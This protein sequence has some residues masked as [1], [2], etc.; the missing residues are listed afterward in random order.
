MSWE[1]DAKILGHHCG[2]E[3]TAIKKI[4]ETIGQVI[5]R[6]KVT[7]CENKILRKWFSTDAQVSKDKKK[8]DVQKARAELENRPN[9]ID[10][11]LHVHPLVV[12]AYEMIVDGKLK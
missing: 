3:D 9:L 10:F 12:A 2:L 5:Q 1:E 8:S 6:E 4:R 7:K 11:C